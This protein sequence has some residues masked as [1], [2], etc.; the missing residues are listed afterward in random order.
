MST[1]QRLRARHVPADRIEAAAV[2][3]VRHRHHLHHCLVAHTLRHYRH[4]GSEHLHPASTTMEEAFAFVAQ[5]RLQGETPDDDDDDR[6]AN[7]VR[8]R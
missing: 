8:L 6:P 4:S 7:D 5:L 2:H 3:R 1:G